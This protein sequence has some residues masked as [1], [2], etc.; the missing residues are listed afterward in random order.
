MQLALVIW[1][2]SAWTGD[3]Q[4]I[5]C[6]SD[7]GPVPWF[8]VYGLIASQLTHDW[9]TFPSVLLVYSPSSQTIWSGAVDV[10]TF[11]Q[12]VSHGEPL[13]T[14]IADNTRRNEARSRARL[15][16]FS[17]PSELVRLKQGRD[18]SAQ[19]AGMLEVFYSALSG[20][21]SLMSYETAAVNVE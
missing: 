7:V 15:I 1:T 2:K 19:Q 5:A 12:S 18:N 9:R 21:R 17:L 8:V 3:S 11:P 13:A 20:A 14:R 16:A 4:S 10:S 6:K